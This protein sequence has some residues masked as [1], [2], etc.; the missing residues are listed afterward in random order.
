MKIELCG[1]EIE[2]NASNTLLDATT[3]DVYR[4][5]HAVIIMINPHSRESLTYARYINY[6]SFNGITYFHFYF[7]DR[8]EAHGVASNIAIMFLLNFRYLKNI[9][10]FIF[11]IY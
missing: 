3:V 1:K 11:L 4:G 5:T 8:E 10:S 7:H 2:L 9:L 6:S